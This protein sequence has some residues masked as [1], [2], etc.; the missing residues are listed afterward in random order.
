MTPEL[1][2]EL[3]QRIGGTWSTLRGP[4]TQAVWA[5][6][7]ERLDHE[8]AVKAVERLS[9]PGASTPSVPDLLA[10]YRSLERAVPTPA[11]TRRDVAGPEFVAAAL[12]DCRAKRDAARTAAPWR[13]AGW[14]AQR[15]TDTE[16]STRNEVPR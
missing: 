12:A 6:A 2:L 5:E 8:R 15:K 11:S 7:L 10:A 9:A 13:K 16:N 1:A 4:K 3:A 14:R